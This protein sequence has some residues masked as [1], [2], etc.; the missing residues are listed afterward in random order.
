MKNLIKQNKGIAITALIATMIRVY[1]AVKVP[2]FVQANACYDDFLFIKYAASMISGNW[3]GSF[4]SVTLAKGSSFSVFIA[5]SYLLGIPYS[6]ALIL[7]YIVSIIILIV[8][9]KKLIKNKY[10]LLFLYLFLL[11]SPVMFHVENTQKIY[12]GGVIVSFSLLIVASIIGIYTRKEQSNKKILRWSLLG[13]FSLAFFWFLKEDSIWILPF[14]CGGILLTIISIFKKKNKIK[15]KVKKGFICLIPLIF[16]ILSNILYCSVNYYKYGVYTITDRNG[17]YLKNVLSDLLLIKDTHKTNQI[18]ITKDMLY[19]AIEVSPTLKKA[20]PNIDKMYQF[21]FPDRKGNGEIVGDIIYWKLKEAFDD[22]GIYKRNGKYANQFYK[23]IDK[24]L[25]EA[26]QKG[27]LKKSK[28]IYLSSVAKGISKEDIPY[29]QKITKD[30]IQVLAT[31]SLNDT[32]IYEATGT[33]ED[34]ILSQHLTNS[35]IVWPNTH[36]SLEKPFKYIVQIVNQ[37]VKWYQKTGFIFFYGGILGLLLLLIQTIREIYHKKYQHLDLVL[38][39]FGLMITGF[40]LLFGVV[41]F[42]RFLSMRKIYD[43]TCALIPII[44]IL[45]VIGIYILFYNLK[46][47]FKA[48]IKKGK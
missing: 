20:E 8:A 48:K 44:Q 42:C 25:Q 7:T 35:L 33:Y 2:L 29:F 3:L 17:T 19:Q 15:V 22:Y 27:K 26:F 14:V 34:I 39:V 36:N 47:I 45:E 41:Y 10:V 21:S 40:V 23:K 1:L 32:G 4:S 43:Y 5:I 24:E 11:F 6:L 12:R 30:T 13:G 31:Y 46:A 28:D 16:L 18:W 37:I 38:I 9:L